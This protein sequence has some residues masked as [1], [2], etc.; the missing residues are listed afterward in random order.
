MVQTMYYSPT[1]YT[2]NSCKP[3]IYYSQCIKA[4]SHNLCTQINLLNGVLDAS[5]KDC[6]LTVYRYIASL[7]N[8][9]F[10]PRYATNSIK[11]FTI[12]N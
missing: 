9:S 10:L 8:Y 1:A 7:L 5:M 11:W 2:A 12:E 6:I 3:Y 4:V